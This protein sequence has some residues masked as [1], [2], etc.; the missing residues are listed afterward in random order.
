[1]K[2]FESS[3]QTQYHLSAGTLVMTFITFLSPDVEF[4]N[5][6][7]FGQIHLHLLSSYEY[8][9]AYKVKNKYIKKQNYFPL[10]LLTINSRLTSCT[11]KLEKG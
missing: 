10:T 11:I 1:M 5:E 8:V 2:I 3:L 4:I 7:M 6:S 9:C